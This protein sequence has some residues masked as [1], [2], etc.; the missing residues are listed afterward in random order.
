[1]Y[2][3]I[4]EVIFIEY[5]INQL[6]QISGV[7]TRTLRYYEQIGLLIPARIS[8]NNYRIYGQKEV[9]ALQQILFYRELGVPLEEIKSLLTAPDYDRKIALQSH[10]AALTEKRERLDLLIQNVGKTI[11]LLRNLW[12]KS[13]I[14]R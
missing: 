12:K 1:M 3:N 10:L 8:S 13:I 6:A 5:A 14:E 2:N 7:T 9:D 11:D 4:Q